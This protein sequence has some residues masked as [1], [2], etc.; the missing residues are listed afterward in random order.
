MAL[1]KKIT[2]SNGVVLEYHRIALIN[3]EVNQQ[4][5]YL[6][7]SYLHAD[8]RQIEKDYAAGL[9]NGDSAANLY[10]PYVDAQYIHTPYDGTMTIEKVYEYLKTLPQFEGAEDV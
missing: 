7:H 2:S 3:I 9:Y 5:T 6:V 1:K 8:G 10:F 4:N